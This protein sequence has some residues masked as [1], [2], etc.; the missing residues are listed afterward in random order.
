MAMEDQGIAKD[1]VARAIR[2]PTRTRRMKIPRRVRFEKDLSSGRRLVVIVEESAD[3]LLVITAWI[4][5]Q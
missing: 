5:K 1:L 4:L 3:S 2:T